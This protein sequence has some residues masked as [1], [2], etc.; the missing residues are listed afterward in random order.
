VTDDAADVP[1]CDP[2]PDFRESMGMRIG[3]PRRLQKGQKRAKVL[4]RRSPLAGP[5]R[6]YCQDERDD[7]QEGRTTRAAPG[8]VAGSATRARG[9]HHERIPAGNS[10]TRNRKRSHMR[11]PMDR[12]QRKCGAEPALP[13][14]PQIPQPLRPTRRGDHHDAP[15]AKWFQPFALSAHPGATW[16]ITI[17][18]PPSRGQ[19]PRWPA[20]YRTGAAHCGRPR[21]RPFSL[22]TGTMRPPARCP[23]S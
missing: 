16:T 4:S 10:P 20:A 14:A 19:H 17:Q 15:R 9:Y 12:R 22:V 8:H 5:L 23:N 6:R 18:S 13:P 2:K 11:H 7:A 1:L 21:G 3:F